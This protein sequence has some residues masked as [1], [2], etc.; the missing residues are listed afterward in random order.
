MY[1]PR[2]GE[3]TLRGQLERVTYR[4]EENG[5][6]VYKIDAGVADL[7]TAVGLCDNHMPG[8]ELELLGDWA[9]H[10]KFGRQFQFTRC[11]S[12]LPSTVEGIKR[13]LGSGL[14]KGVGPRMAERIVKTFGERALDV[15]D[16]SP[17]DLLEIKGVSAKL[18]ESI[19]QSWES[20]K[21]VR[22]VMLFLQSNGVSPNFAAKIFAE[23]GQNTI[24]I[25]K[26]N[27]YRL[28]D[29]IFGI[30]FLTADKVAANM[31]LP[32]ESS[33]RLDAGVQYALS[34][35]TGEGHVY[36]P[37]DVLA[38]RAA[39]LLGVAEGLADEA[40]ARAVSDSALVIDM[41]TPD[42][43]ETL[44]AVYLPTYYVA[45]RKSAKKLATL[46][47]RDT[48]TDLDDMANGIDIERAVA[49]VQNVM[50][51]KLAEKQEG[52]LKLALT[53]KV[54]II[55]GGPGTGKT[56][57]IKAII[58]ILGA[59]NLEI[60]LAAPTGRAA[61]RM[62]EATGHEARTIHRLLEYNGKMGGF[63]RNADSP[64]E[65]GL[66]VVDEASMIDSVLFFH[67]LRAIPDETKLILVG[68]IHQLP[69]VG[70][71]NVLKDLISSGAAPVV[72]LNEIFR[73]AKESG[74]IVNAHRVNSGLLPEE[75]SDGTGEPGA[76]D[77]FGEPAGQTHDGDGLR[78]FYFVTQDDPEKC[79][80]II[81]TLVR[82]RIPAR[83]GLNPISD[84]Q[85]LTPMHRGS[86][87]ASNLNGALQRALNPDDRPSIER[88]GRRFKV[89][90]KVMQIRND[91]ER[92]VYNG[93]IGFVIR[94]DDEAGLLS[95][96][97]YGREIVY[98]ANGF[99]ALIHAYAVS[100]HKSQ[101]SEYPA[102]VMPIHTQH[103]VL[104]Q[105][106]LLYTGITRGKKLVVLVGTKKAAAIAVKNDKTRHRYTYL[107]ERLR[108][109]IL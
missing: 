99:D 19:K 54:M 3:K 98:E 72:E 79:V 89:G 70:P 83:F 76:P 67:L 96:D 23:Y 107:G 61:K 27:P 93:D 105:R 46:L 56:T 32:P 20:Q 106:N 58:G 80:Q 15:L 64:L 55:T 65:C 25:V 11:R 37:R 1:E 41:I 43:G 57:L 94:A 88:G 100:I 86:L 71:G 84:V 50:R 90:D 36:A 30:G 60:E 108:Q 78:D 101:G 62:S 82:D 92:D 28:A 5:Y 48:L 33:T 14:V 63:A 53:S 39:L 66:L 16:E 31:G 29:D 87:G 8:E 85:V 45:E 9:N 49:W 22:S 6:S 34:E 74:I 51:I 104:L 4:N 18:L 75:L 47:R 109:A 52:A 10:P 68:D 24:Q 59:R 13:Y 102:I 35:F 38:K 91:Y 44:E 7:V 73:Q 2:P 17:D 69:S 81:L 42:G 95:V 26:E 97:M 77:E 40:I 21:E 12:L 103:Y